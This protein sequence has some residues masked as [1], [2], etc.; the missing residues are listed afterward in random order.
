MNVTIALTKK[1]WCYVALWRPEKK[2]RFLKVFGQQKNLHKLP[3]LRAE[4]NKE[5][6]NKESE[7]EPN[8][9]QPYKPN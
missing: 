7:T 2:K 6:R 8:K 4:Y 9:T 5:K 1:V 3:N